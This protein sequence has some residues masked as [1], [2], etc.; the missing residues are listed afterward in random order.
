MLDRHLDAGQAVLGDDGDPA[1]AGRQHVAERGAHAGADE[2]LA[3]ADHG[4]AGAA[5]AGAPGA[6]MR[7]ATSVGDRPSMSTMRSATSV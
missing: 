2:D 6:T 4:A 5:G 7:S 1:H 3:D